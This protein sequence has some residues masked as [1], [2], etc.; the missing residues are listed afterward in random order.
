MTC[1]E[2]GATDCTAAFHACLAADFSDE[3]YGIV[4]HLVVAAYGLQHRWY[5]AETASMMV[6]FV[7][8]HLD[9]PPSD[10]DRRLIRQAADGSVR[11]RARQPEG[12]SPEWDLSVGD[13]DLGSADT[14]QSTVR[15][16]ARSVAETLDG[17]TTET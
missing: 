11:V 14:Y 12:P 4:H 9:R 10:H 3:R 5:P 8:G 16:W 15:T 2:C 17:P 13:V 6:E 1:R 7:R